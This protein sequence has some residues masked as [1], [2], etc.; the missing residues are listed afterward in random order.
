MRFKLVLSLGAGKTRGQ[1]SEMK[2]AITGMLL[3]VEKSGDCLLKEIIEK[4]ERL[5]ETDQWSPF[6]TFSEA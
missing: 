5:Y 2:F 1:G 3:Q 4:K 6:Y